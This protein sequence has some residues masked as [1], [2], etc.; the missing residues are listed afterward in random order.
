MSQLSGA[1]ARVLLTC[2][3]ASSARR[4]H[5]PCVCIAW[6]QAAVSC[7]RSKDCWRSLSSCRCCR[8]FK[9][10]AER[11]RPWMPLARRLGRTC[12]PFGRPTYTASMVG[13]ARSC[14]VGWAGGAGECEL[15]RSSSNSRQ[16]SCWSGGST[17]SA[18]DLVVGAEAAADLVAPGKGSSACAAARGHS[19]H[20]A[21]A[22]QQ[23]RGPDDRV[24]GHLP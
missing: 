11:A 18:G 9:Q 15:A 7:A 24:C 22:W 16:Q 21:V 12:R 5:S 4:V 13:S 3:P 14:C 6:V 19:G 10:G 23:A 1:Q 20:G 2:L 17:A 8:C